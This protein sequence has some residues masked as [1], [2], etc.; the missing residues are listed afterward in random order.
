MAL[1]NKNNKKPV[2]VSFFSGC[3]GL[4]LGF[5]AA[6]FDVKLAVEF[7][8]YACD[9]LRANFPNLKV[10]GPPDHDG[11]ISKLTDTEIYNFSGLKPGEIDVVIGGPP[12]QSFSVAA[13]QRFVKGDPRFKRMGYEDEKRGS[14]LASY[15]NLIVKLKPKAFL[16][17]NVP[18]IVSID[19]GKQ[20]SLI[21]DIL[22]AGGYNV[23]GPHIINAADYGIPQNRKRAIII[24]SRNVKDLSFPKFTH[25]IHDYLNT[26]KHVSV[27]H[28]L[29]GITA[30]MP[31]HITRNHSNDS[32]KRYKRLKIGERDSLGRV[33]RLNPWKPSKTIIA[34]GSRGGGRSHLHPFVPRTLSVR[35]SARLQ[36]FNDDFIFTGS[37]ARQ[38][39]QVGNAV[40]P[41]L[42]EIIAR[43]LME[44]QFGLNFSIPF[45]NGTFI[46]ESI[47]QNKAVDILFKQSQKEN[48]DLYIDVVDTAFNDKKTF[49]LLSP[50]GITLNSLKTA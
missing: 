23:S 26:K 35:E 21:K 7:A 11:D 18:G 28:A 36:T 2:V 12:C 45:K 44:K 31:N 16:I 1:R 22:I 17:E 6:G 24:G 41:L 38:F 43:H 47:S 15:V 33:D 48:K 10:M 42:G 19:G 30:G 40:P 39:T 46:N 27:A 5:E 20:F 49:T 3:G 37:I 29:A 25:S 9:T 32:L 50:I 14:L 13:A 8:D 4:D 34:G